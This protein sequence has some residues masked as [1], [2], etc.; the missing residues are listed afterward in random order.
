MGFIRPILSTPNKLF[1]ISTIMNT[2]LNAKK[3]RFGIYICLSLL[4]GA[5]YVSDTW[6][7]EQLNRS[8]FS[9]LAESEN[10]FLYLNQTKP[11]Q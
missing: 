2:N 8:D 9:S 4:L 11:S 3:I 10:I 5:D 7:Q 6:L 1:P